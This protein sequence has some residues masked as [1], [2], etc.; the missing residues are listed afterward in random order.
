MKYKYKKID[1]QH[2]VE[3]IETAVPTIN[4]GN[5]DLISLLILLLRR[6]GLKM[7]TEWHGTE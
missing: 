5:E 2:V 4:E 7:E 6:K 1:L 3:A